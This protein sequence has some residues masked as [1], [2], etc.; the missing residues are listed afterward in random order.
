MTRLKYSCVL[1]TLA[2]LISFQSVQAQSRFEI[3]TGAGLFE[4]IFLKAKYGEIVQ[5][6]LSQDLVSQ[7]HTTGLELYYRLPRRGVPGTA[8]PFY[9]MCGVSTTLFGKGYDAFEKSYLY[10][11]L[12]RS[13]LIP[14]RSSR[15]GLNADLG[16]AF[17]RSTN[18]PEGY[19]TELYS[20]S[21]SLGVFYR[22]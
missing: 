8:G 11:R 17:L 2:L 5:I 16:V 21:G 7:L 1:L 10:P 20:I 22:F 13:F 4:G 3:S 12:G 6:G 15:F 19:I 9:V 14:G 18:P